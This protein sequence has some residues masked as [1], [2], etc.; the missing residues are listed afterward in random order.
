M[1]RIRTSL[2]VLV[3]MIIAQGLRA[4]AALAH[5]HGNEA[6][7]PRVI[8]PNAR[9]V[10]IRGEV[11]DPTIYLKEGKHGVEVGDRIEKAADQGQPLAILEE[12]T[13]KLYWMLPEKPGMDPNQFVVDH[14][15]EQVTVSGYAYERGGNQ[16]VVA[17]DVNLVEPPKPEPPTTS[18]RTP[19]RR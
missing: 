4:P 10:T 13:G 9:A 5:A 3:W 14:I 17:V 2:V 19:V 1:P 12:G 8:D 6:E 18:R 11:V 15:A 16:G 7:P